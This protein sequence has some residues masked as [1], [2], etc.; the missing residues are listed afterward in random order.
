MPAS[1]NPV[2]RL[3]HIKD[4][5]DGITAALSGVRRESFLDSYVLIRAAERA[6]QIISEAVR[7]LPEDTLRGHSEVDWVALRA[8]GNVLRHEYQAIDPGTLWEIMTGGKLRE[9]ASVIASMLSEVGG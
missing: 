1:R 6:L 8:L 7:S 4:E 3:Q 9:L 5:I 2:V